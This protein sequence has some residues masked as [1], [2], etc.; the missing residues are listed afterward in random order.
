MV[1]QLFECSGEVVVTGFVIEI[2]LGEQNLR[3]YQTVSFKQVFVNP[4]QSALPDCRA[5][6][7]GGELRWSGRQADG[8]SPEPN[9]A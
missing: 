7:S 3:T 1:K 5:S 8:V 9:S 6:L 4:H 2:R